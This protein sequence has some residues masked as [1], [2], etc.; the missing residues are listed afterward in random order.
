MKLN[1]IRKQLYKEVYLKHAN[2]SKIAKEMNRQPIY[3]WRD[4]PYLKLKYYLIIEFSAMISFICLRLNIHP[5][6][7][8]TAG[9]FS[10]F[11]SFI[12]LSSPFVHVN[13]IALIIFFF[14]KYF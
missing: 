3:R 2:K 14:K 7:I 10:A 8:T 13:L 12:F 9:V 1:I 5:N 4:N 6:F 11:L